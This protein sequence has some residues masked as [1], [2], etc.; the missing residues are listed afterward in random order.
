VELEILPEKQGWITKVN[1]V[2][3]LYYG[4]PEII[5]L[6]I[7]EKLNINKFIPEGMKLKDWTSK[8]IN[9]FR[10]SQAYGPRFSEGS[11]EHIIGK[12]C[13]MCY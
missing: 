4:E 5:K 2:S 8:I 1:L 9:M 12:G 6:C 13:I 11:N 3:D 7:K 10:E